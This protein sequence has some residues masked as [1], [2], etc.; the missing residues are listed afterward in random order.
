MLER[1][2]FGAATSSGAFLPLYGSMTSRR[3]HS[4][5]NG[6]HSRAVRTGRFRSAA[7]ATGRQYPVNGPW[8]ELLG[9]QGSMAGESRSVH[10]GDENQINSCSFRLLKSASCQ[11]TS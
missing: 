3:L 5:G 6:R 10:T 1:T 7:R 8:C 9:H 4:S 11:L 2:C